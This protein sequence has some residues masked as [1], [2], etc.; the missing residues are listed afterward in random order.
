M[1]VRWCLN[2]TII[3]VFSF[4]IFL[5]AGYINLIR[6][7]QEW[8][9]KMYCWNSISNCTGALRAPVPF[10]QPSWTSLGQSWENQGSPLAAQAIGGMV[11]V[12]L[13][14]VWSPQFQFAPLE[15]D[16]PH[17]MSS[18]RIAGRSMWG[19]GRNFW[20]IV[21]LAVV[22][23][24]FHLL[25]T[26]IWVWYYRYPKLGYLGGASGML[27]EWPGWGADMQCWGKEGQGVSRDCSDNTCP[28]YQQPTKLGWLASPLVG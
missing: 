11:Q 5:N 22:I 4:W 14:M 26:S 7:W 15:E 21:W 28:S 27:T 23:G 13:G 2:S 19:T 9:S 24:F 25:W 6:Q 17:L 8:I 18:L 16:S 3:C 12:L 1:I 20:L 10:A